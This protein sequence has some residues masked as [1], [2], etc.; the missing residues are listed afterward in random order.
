MGYYNVKPVIK[1]Y[2]LKINCVKLWTAW[3]SKV[4]IS[5]LSVKQ[6]TN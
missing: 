6:D 4:Q 5:A 2:N 1:A 3:V